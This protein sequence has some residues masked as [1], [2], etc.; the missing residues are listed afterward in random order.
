[1]RSLSY[2]FQPMEYASLTLM[3]LLY[4]IVLILLSVWPLS[5]TGRAQETTFDGTRLL[6][7][8]TVSD[9]R[10]VFTYANDL[11]LVARTGGKAL[12]LTSHAG[13]ESFAHLSPDGKWI[14]F[15]GQQG[16]D[17]DIY[18]MLSDGGAP[19]RLTYYPGYEQVLGWTP[20]SKRI[21]F[22]S[23]RASIINPINKLFTVGL[24]GGFPQELPLPDSGL[25][26]FSPDGTRLA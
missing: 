10:I 17:A 12:Q 1:M 19:K 7:M 16:G 2:G 14:A 5:L 23:R 8:P 3:K 25:A 26:S 22:H 9:D 6:R 13:A 18:V 21:L 15:T 20:D 24:E 4:M 11:W